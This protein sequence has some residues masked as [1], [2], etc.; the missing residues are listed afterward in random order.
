MTQATPRILMCDDESHILRAAS[1]KLTKAGL[2]VETATD[3]QLGWEAIQAELPSMLITDYQMPRLNGLELCRRLRAEPATRDLPIV[4][5]TAKGYEFDWDT[6]ARELWLT[7][8]LVK[9]F[10][11]RELLQLVQ[12]TLGLVG[13]A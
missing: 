1:M 12:E 5:L 4:L 7:R 9:P 11:P 8:V 3:G 6:L 13:Q 2:I 10:S